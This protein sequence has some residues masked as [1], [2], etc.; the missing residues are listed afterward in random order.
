MEPIL[1]ISTAITSL[2]TATDIAQLLKT[3]DSSFEKAEL[4]LKIADMMIALADAKIS[5]AELKDIIQDKDDKIK[6][7][8]EQNTLV[9]EMDFKNGLYFSKNGDGP[10]CTACYDT[11]K[12][13]IRLTEQPSA[14]KTFGDY[15]CPNCGNL[16]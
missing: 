14:F 5:I 13:K 10:Y 6:Q 12:I 16:F 9:E 15:K 4:R 11:K 8:Q 7:L 2:K 1:A 3:T